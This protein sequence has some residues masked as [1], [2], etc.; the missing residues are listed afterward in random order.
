MRD[1]YAADS[2]HQHADDASDEALD[3]AVGRTRL[4]Q[5]ARALG[6]LVDAA[7]LAIELPRLR[8]G[9][10]CER[11]RPQGGKRLGAEHYQ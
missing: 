10:L 3:D 11:Q 6:E 9:D 5:P 4:G 2:Q 8:A 7:V 1:G